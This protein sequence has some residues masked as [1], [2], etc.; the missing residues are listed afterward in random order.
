MP[1]IGIF[2]S[3]NDLCTFCEELIVTVSGPPERIM[4]DGFIL[5]IS[6]VD[7]EDGFTS[8]KTP[9]SLTLLAIN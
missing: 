8:E 6:S 5:I 1:K 2:A 7:I 4:P 9:I 3:N